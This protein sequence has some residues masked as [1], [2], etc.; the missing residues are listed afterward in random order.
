MFDVYVCFCG[1]QLK[2]SLVC[3]I[4][5]NL[6]KGKNN[7]YFISI[8]ADCGHLGKLL[9]FLNQSLSVIFFE[10]CKNNAMLLR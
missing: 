6:K 4:K 8:L 7:V 5:S 1:G 2:G 10:T 9:T 3:H